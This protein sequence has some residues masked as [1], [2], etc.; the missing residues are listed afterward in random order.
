MRVDSGS[1]VVTGGASGLG[2]ATA[3][4]LSKRGARVVIAD[5]PSSAG[6]ERAAELGATFIPVDVTEDGP[7]RAAIDA[8]VALGPLRV[9]VTCAGIGTPGRVVSRGEPM[10]LEQFERV[11]R[12]NLVGTF[13]AIRLAAQAMLANEP[14][15]GDRG[16]IV[17]TASVAAFDG[18]IG[19]AAYSAS[20]GG[21]AGMLLPIARDLADK[22]IRV[23][24][25]APGTFRTPMLAGLPQDTQ[26]SLAAQI[27]H[28]ARLGD[29]AEYAALV[30]HIIDNGMLNGEV[31]RLDGAIRMAPR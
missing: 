20:K 1:A 7:M 3:T 25:I 6:P 12:V 8:A 5:L 9:L 15:D 18:Q 2:L 22:A 24:C 11:V 10:P 27:P 29:P 13:N 28:P 16:V 14:V 19:Q 4:E 30:G 26:N 31:I 17:T 23:M 21:V